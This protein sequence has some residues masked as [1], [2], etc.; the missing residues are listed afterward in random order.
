MAHYQQKCFC[1]RVKQQFPSYFHGT[2][3]LDCGSYCVNGD[4]RHLF[5]EVKYTGI[6]LAVGKNVDIVSKTH[7]F[8]LGEVEQYDLIISTEC[9]EHDQYF[10]LSIKRIIELLKPNGLFVF[11]C[12]TTGREEHGTMRSKPEDSP[13][14]IRRGDGW[15]DYYRN[16][17]P[18]QAII[19]GQ[20]FHHFIVEVNFKIGDLYFWGHNKR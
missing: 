16:I 4:N 14:T 18:E 15:E 8:R 1:E 7:E 11:T 20:S 12:A 13:F 19:I 6:D 9:F 17:R 3:V 2:D 5:T 10:D